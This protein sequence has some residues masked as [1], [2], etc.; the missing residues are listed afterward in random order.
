MKKILILSLYLLSPI[1]QA[2][3][4]DDSNRFTINGQEINDIKTGL[5]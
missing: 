4:C 1:L 3:I 5:I 2:Q